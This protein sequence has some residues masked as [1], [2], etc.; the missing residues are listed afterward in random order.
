MIPIDLDPD[1]LALIEEFEK[2]FGLLKAKSEELLSASYDKRYEALMKRESD[3][4]KFPVAPGETV[5][6]SIPEEEHSTTYPEASSDP[7]VPDALFIQAIRQTQHRATI[8]R[9][10]MSREHVWAIRQMSRWQKFGSD[11]EAFYKRYFELWLR[12]KEIK[13]LRTIDERRAEIHQRIPHVV[14]LQNLAASFYSKDGNYVS[15][16]AYNYRIAVKDR[17]EDLAATLRSA[18]NLFDIHERM[19]EM[20][21]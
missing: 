18:E 4:V 5:D 2:V 7:E 15:G 8:R 14:D 9:R 13:T 11:V 16:E 3:Y 19:R 12:Q 10:M 6:L 20:Q 1:D 21:I 17:L